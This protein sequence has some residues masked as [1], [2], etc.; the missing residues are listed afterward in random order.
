MARSTR[1][2]TLENRTARLK[3]DA[4]KRHTVAIG[5]GLQLQYRRGDHSSTWYAKILKGDDKYLLHTLGQADDSQDANGVDIR[6]QLA[7]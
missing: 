3:L 4:K 1:S 2:S 7:L 5:K 6:V